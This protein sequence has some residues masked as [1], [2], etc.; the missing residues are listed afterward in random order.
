MQGHTFQCTQL[1]FIITSVVHG[2]WY[3]KREQVHD[4]T[5]NGAAN[6]RRTP[7][8]SSQATRFWQGA[9]RNG[10]NISS[11]H[12]NTRKSKTHFHI[13]K[14]GKNHQIRVGLH[15]I[16]RAPEVGPGG[17]FKKERWDRSAETDHM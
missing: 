1:C 10:R 14:S 8:T 4:R 6:G 15:V 17:G 9:Q 12:K 3:K 16:E 2:S 11:F 7:T 5:W 13:L